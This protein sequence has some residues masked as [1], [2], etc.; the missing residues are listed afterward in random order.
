MAACESEIVG[1]DRPLYLLVSNMLSN[2][3]VVTT[4]WMEIAVDGDDCGICDIAVAETKMLSAW[5]HNTNSGV[6][7]TGEA[8]G[9]RRKGGKRSRL[10]L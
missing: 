7:T 10:R 1:G 2:G 3:D 6:N 4:E 9:S 5:R 8:N